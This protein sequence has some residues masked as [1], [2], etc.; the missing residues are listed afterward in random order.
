MLLWAQAVGG[1]LVFLGSFLPWWSISSPGVPGFI[2]PVTVSINGFDDGAWGAIFL[3]L[4]LAITA[5]AV[6]KVLNVQVPALNNLPSWLPLVVTGLTFLFALI[7]WI[8]V[9]G[10]EGGGSSI[11]IWLL[12]LGALAAFGATL[13]PVLQARKA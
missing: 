7:K 4:G 6:I 3:I 12:F 8:D 2:E 1:F 10:V 11:G 5:W 9:L 13:L